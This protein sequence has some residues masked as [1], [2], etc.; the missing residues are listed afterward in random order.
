[1]EINKSGRDLG[2]DNVSRFL[3]WVA[4]R[5]AARD[6]QD[7]VRGGR[8]NRSEIAGECNFALSVLRQN[9]R[10]RAA[11]DGLETRLR[12]SGELPAS[13]QAS[14]TS[15]DKKSVDAVEQRITRATSRMDI[16]LK[17]LEEQN[18]AL[19]AE[20]ESLRSQLAKYKLISEHLEETGRLLQP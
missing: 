20:V 8:L 9:P 6:W 1:M 14:G 19:R 13:L 4:E 15:S 2:R 11:L 12:D 7:Y 18:A 16:R 10:V 5:D 17:T 3:G